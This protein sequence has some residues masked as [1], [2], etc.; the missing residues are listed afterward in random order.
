MNESDDEWIIEEGD[1]VE[2]EQTQ[3]EGDGGYVDL[4]GADL[5]DPTPDALDLD[6]MFFIT[7]LIIWRRTGW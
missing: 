3:V 5:N 6:N 4:V 1:N 7:T 2:V